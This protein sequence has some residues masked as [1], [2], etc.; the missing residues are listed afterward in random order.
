MIFPQNPDN[1]ARD[2]T[3]SVTGMRQDKQ[4]EPSEHTVK[5]NATGEN[6]SNQKST[7][8]STTNLPINLVEESADIV[9][10]LKSVVRSLSA[11]LDDC[12]V[13]SIPLVAHLLCSQL[14]Q[15]TMA[16][17]GTIESSIPQVEGLAGSLS[18]PVSEGQIKGEE[19]RETLEQ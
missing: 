6:G 19:R 16:C 10:L 12:D 4:S 7:A 18:A 3:R 8:Y 15:Q 13:W 5:P 14:S 9:P 1:A 2:P 11:I 17:C